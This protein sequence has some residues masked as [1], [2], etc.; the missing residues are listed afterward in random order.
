MRDRGALYV[1]VLLIALG[2]LFMFTQVAGTLLSPWGLRFGWSQMW[3]FT[4]LFVGFAFWLP[5]VLWWDRRQQVA[6][7][8]IPAT[9]ITANGLLL[10]YQNLTGDWDSWAYMWALEPISVGLGL[11]FLYF[12]SVRQPGLLTA[13]AIVCGIGLFFFAIFASIFGGVLRILGPA[14]LILIGILIMLNAVNRRA[15][16]GMPQE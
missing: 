11:L 14:A 3:P 15:K 8:A 4:I 16:G 6:G 12:L 2:I 5:I 9:I 10:L 13:A 1:G 7:L